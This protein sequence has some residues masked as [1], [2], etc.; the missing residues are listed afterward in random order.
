MASS[1][2]LQILKRCIL[3]C[4]VPNASIFQKNGAPS[5]QNPFDRNMNCGFENHGLFDRVV[6]I[7]S[8]FF[9]KVYGKNRVGIQTRDQPVIYP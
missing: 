3:I 8:S 4:E 9:P 1:G 5:F 7:F 6:I 2:S